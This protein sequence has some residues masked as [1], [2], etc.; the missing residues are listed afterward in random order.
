MEPNNRINKVNNTNTSHT[1]SGDTIEYINVGTVMQ[2]STG[3]SVEVIFQNSPWVY[4]IN[5]D[6]LK[7]LLAG[8]RSY[9]TIA[10]KKRKP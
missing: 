7:K 9:T 2:S 5:A 1:V 10:V 8:E 3:K 6:G 4:Y